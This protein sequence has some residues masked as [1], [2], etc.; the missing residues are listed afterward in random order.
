M[1]RKSWDELLMAYLTSTL[2]D[3]DRA[4]FD[5][6]LSEC[7]P[8]RD[9]LREWRIIAQAA[10]RDAD[11]RAGTLPPLPAAFYERLHVQPSAN[12][13]QANTKG[14]M[15]ENM[16]ALVGN[17]YKEKR[18]RSQGKPL[19]L[20]AAVAA[21]VLGGLLLLSG[22]G[23]GPSGP[24]LPLA[25]IMGQET[26]PTPLITASPLTNLDPMM[27]TATAIIAGA[28]GTKA[29][30]DGVWTPAPD[31]AATIVP[32]DLDPIYLTATAILADATGTK[33]VQDGIWTPAP[34]VT[35]TATS[36]PTIIPSASATFTATPFSGSEMVLPTV[37]PPTSSG[38]QP[39]VS[40]PARLAE[41]TQVNGGIH[42]NG[43][44]MSADGKYLAVQNG[45]HA[46]QV[47]AASTLELAATIDLPDT[48]VTASAFGD[49]LLA[50]GTADGRVQF[51]SQNEPQREALSGFGVVSGLTFSPDGTQLLI[52]SDT[53]N[54][55]V[56]W[57]YT[58]EAKV[59]SALLFYD[60]P[61]ASAA[62]NADGSQIIVGTLDGR[63][64][65]LDVSRN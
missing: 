30:E 15:E 59:Q 20:A 62:F 54:M 51:W 19:T 58:L 52:S 45:D 17:T 16:T 57:L 14:D 5:R 31:M 38:M 35:A 9:E 49:N 3:D 64:L 61:L 7:E 33:A 36:L 60:V 4:D 40:S 13:S 26:T 1:N 42:E 34:D 8:C 56:L 6:Y 18:K 12:G 48:T 28:T 22:G 46:V 65:V 47:F 25:G 41:E 2:S 11:A 43:V 21:V 10:R 37:E 29:V 63:V 53:A 32:P 39:M 44:V 50:I 27:Q 23:G 24:I 55:S